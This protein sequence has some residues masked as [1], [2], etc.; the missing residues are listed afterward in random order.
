MLRIGRG[1]DSGPCRVCG[2][3][4]I[5][6]Q[7]IHRLDRQKRLVAET[8]R[9]CGHVTLPHNTHDYTKAA[10]AEH[11][12]LAARVGTLERPGREFGMAQLALDALDRDPVDV[13]VY[14]AGRSM[15]NHHI[16]RLAGVRD[17]AIGDVVQVRDD[18]PFI[19]ISQPGWRSFDIVVAA[20]VIEHFEQPREEFPRL[21]S[22]VSDNG[23]VVCSTNVYDGGPLVKQAY[24]FGR[25]HVSYYTPHSLRL[26]ADENE[27]LVDFRP[28]R[29]VTGR[30]GPRKRYV[31]LTRSADV[32]RAI[33][34]YFGQ[35]LYAPSEPPTAKRA[36]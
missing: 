26:L 1:S 34:D 13:L 25:G 18:A 32:M 12:G 29:A 23:L 19:D 22:Y 35:H 6:R 3:Q 4:R 9:E 36:C 28:P 2:A 33:S 10:A 17:V 30:V 31:L 5:H 27:F 24:I 11:F 16:A 20:E 14:G 15:D 21:L 7:V 8:C